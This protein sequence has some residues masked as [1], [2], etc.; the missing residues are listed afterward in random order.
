MTPP[1]AAATQA[2]PG[3]LATTSQPPKEHR[4]YTQPPNPKPEVVTTAH[5][6]PPVPEVVTAYHSMPHRP[7]RPTP[8]A[9][10]CFAADGFE[11]NKTMD[12]LAFVSEIRNI[13]PVNYIYVSFQ[14]NVST[15]KKKFSNAMPCIQLYIIF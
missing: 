9:E 15:L 6:V 1:S 5:T 2:T 10:G 3:Q 13:P 11:D 12:R 8:A 7:H 14:I 4:P